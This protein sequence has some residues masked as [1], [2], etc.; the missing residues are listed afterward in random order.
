MSD[1]VSTRA[2]AILAAAEHAA[3]GGPPTGP[4]PPIPAPTPASAWPPPPPPG[5]YSPSLPTTQ[6]GQLLALVDA[7]VAGTEE[8]KR[9]LD[10][11]ARTLEEL[12]HRVQG[13][14]GAPPGPFA[15]SPE[16]AA[17]Q[18]APYAPAAADIMAAGNVMAG[19]MSERF[20]SEASPGAMSNRSR[21]RPPRGS[22]RPRASAA[23]EAESGAQETPG[24]PDSLNSTARL[25]AIEMA[26]GGSTRIQVDRRLRDEYGFTD[27]AAILEDVFGAG[28]QPGT[29]MPWGRRP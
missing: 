8:A 29:Q 3:Q 15:P 18:P 19:E 20:P 28:S 13:E 1:S 17:R 12:T 22:E 4:T 2:Q 6:P 25:I 10:E 7:V 5:S 11:L 23:V 24:P 26:V 16:P 27:A 9:R 14:T 21:P